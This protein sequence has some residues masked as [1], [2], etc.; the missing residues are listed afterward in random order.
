[1]EAHLQCSDGPSAA[2]R[3]LQVDLDG[4]W[5]VPHGGGQEPRCNIYTDANARRARLSADV[6]VLVLV[7]HRSGTEPHHGLGAGLYRQQYQVGAT[8]LEDHNL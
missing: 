6:H 5:A 7:A 8:L 4:V 1:V 3:W 2:Q